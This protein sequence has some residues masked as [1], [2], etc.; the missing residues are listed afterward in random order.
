MMKTNRSLIALVVALGLI[1]VVLHATIVT[2]VLTPIR[3]DLRTDVNTIQW[4]ITGY[5]I[6]NAA[7]I[8]VGGYLANCF[9]RKRMFLLGLLVFTTGSV[10]SGLSPGIGWL[11]AF[12][13]LQGVGGGLQQ[14]LG[15]TLASRSASWA[16]RWWGIAAR[17]AIGTPVPAWYPSLHLSDG[18]DGMAGGVC[19]RRI[20][21]TGK[22]PQACRGRS[23]RLLINAQR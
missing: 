21:D 17:Q 20:S 9:G 12:R 10:L 15:P 1:P 11:I 7:V 13:V 18:L 23:T 14:A 5:L 3:D 8:T 19:L 6:A 22:S 2:V 4:I 16:T